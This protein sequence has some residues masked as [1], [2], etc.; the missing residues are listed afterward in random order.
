MNHQNAIRP[1]YQAS[2]IVTGLKGTCTPSPNKTEPSSSLQTHGKQGTYPD[3]TIVRRT[4]PSWPVSTPVEIK[5]AQAAAIRWRQHQLNIKGVLPTTIP[6]SHHRWVA[7]TRRLHQPCVSTEYVT[8]MAYT[9]GVRYTT[10]PHGICEGGTA[11]AMSS[12]TLTMQ[13]QGATSSLQY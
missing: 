5:C 2:D 10:V 11:L 13:L 4:C 7:V 6:Q 3:S 9:C 1:R 12:C 8:D